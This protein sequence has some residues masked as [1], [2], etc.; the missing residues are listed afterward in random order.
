M[1]LITVK[2]RAAGA[3][4]GLSNIPK[5]FIDGLV[6]KERLLFLVHKLAQSIEK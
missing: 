1:K 3:L 5:Y 6:E 2:D 4:V